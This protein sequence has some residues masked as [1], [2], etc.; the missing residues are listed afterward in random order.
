MLQAKLAVLYGKIV[1]GPTDSTEIR[2]ASKYYRVAFYGQ[3]FPQCV[4]VS[5]LH[6]TTSRD[7]LTRRRQEATSSG[8]DVV[9][10]RNLRYATSHDVA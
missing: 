9:L 4:R 7:V 5:D 6:Y 2:V 3:Q 10:L 8:H 1:P